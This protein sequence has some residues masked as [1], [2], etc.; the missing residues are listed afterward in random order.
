MPVP[1]CVPTDNDSPASW[2]VKKVI[3]N[4]NTLEKT[5][6]STVALITVPGRHP[7]MSSVSPDPYTFPNTSAVQQPARFGCFATPWTAARQASL[8]IANFQSLLK[9]MSIEL[10]MPSNHLF[11]V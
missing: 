6:P 7:G 4:T 1:F 3:N 5:P 9:L 11:T 10:A 2:D 8:S